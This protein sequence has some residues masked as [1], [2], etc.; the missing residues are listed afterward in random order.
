MAITDPLVLPADVILVPVDDLPEAVQSKLQYE[1]GD[2]AITRPRA[3]TPSKIVDAEA[4]S[5]LKQFESPKTYVEAVIHFSRD[6]GV[7]PEETLE[8]A[9]PLIRYLLKATLL[10]DAESADAGGIARLFDFG[11]LVA[12]Y[13][14]VYCIQVLDDTEL[15]LVKRQGEPH[16]VLKILRPTAGA[17]AGQLLQRDVAI[18]GMLD[19]S[20]SPTLLDAGMYEEQPYLIMS[21]CAG[22]EAASA[23]EELRRAGDG[24]DLVGLSDLCLKILQAYSHL[25]AQGVLHGDIHPRNLLIGADGAV[26][27]VDFGLARHDS[28]DSDLSRANRGGVG[29]FF[30][31]E[32]A[33]A[34]LN[35][36]RPPQVTARSEQYALASLI[37]HLLTG[38]DY[39]DFSLERD[40]MLQQICDQDPL[41]F[42]YW[43]VSSSPQVERVLFKALSKNPDGR[44][45]SV[46]QFAREF[47]Q[48]AL[49]DNAALAA[50]GTGPSV[51]KPSAAQTLLDDI[52]LELEPDGFLFTS[53][54]PVG[55]TCSV[56]AGAA[57]IAHALYRIA[58]AR[59]SPRLL[60]HADI[61]SA[62]AVRD[63]SN[64]DAF[65]NEEL[66]ATPDTLGRISPFHTLSGV[67][68]VQALIAHAMG[69]QLLQQTA[70]ESFVETAQEPCDVLD[71]TLGHS[72]I[73]LAGSLLLDTMNGSEFLDTGPLRQLGDQTMTHIWHELSTHPPI[74]EDRELTTLGIAHGWAGFIYAA[75]RW[76][77]SSGSRLPDQVGDRLQQLAELA[78]PIVRGARWKWTLER[79]GPGIPFSYMSGWCNGS[80][81]YVHLWTTA[82]QWFEEEKFLNLARSAAWN[83][84]EQPQQVD[85]LCCG[86]AG[87]SYALI[88]LFKF[89][90]EP[91]WLERA[92]VLAES[93][94]AADPTPDM[95]AYSLYKGKVG[96]AVLAADLEQVEGAAMPFFGEEGWPL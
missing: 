65:V 92:R 53:G 2:Y 19:G 81:G 50:G 72:S 26:K 48:A 13:Q 86:L 84:W 38:Y 30:D 35:R 25:Q 36:R 75:M 32:Y 69:D 41:P 10:V 73:L 63:R 66:Q 77:R 1:D 3:R 83:V 70:V 18:L 31:P 16:V 6:S 55:P 78:E 34:I 40:A 90:G 59:Q 20:V 88:N 43:E 91:A 42:S 94:A 29:F 74:I 4:A 23:A 11:D 45:S 21:W 51:R 37:Y 8:S 44:F 24:G 46:A 82:H 47:R 9:Y 14:V 79:P 68:A 17:L 64:D 27:I 67:Y 52:L 95:P 58:C 62:R 33:Q 85:N 49:Q 87:R 93:A 7:D 22:I 54:L 5:L 80:A 96:V 39:L 28:S 71:L 89:T 15:Y 12:G 56:T 61:W 60:A 57:G 76:C